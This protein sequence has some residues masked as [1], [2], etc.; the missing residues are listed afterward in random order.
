LPLLIGLFGFLALQAVILLLSAVKLS[1]EGISEWRSPQRITAAC[2]MR[3][4][5]T[6]TSQRDE[7]PPQQQTVQRHHQMTVSR[8]QRT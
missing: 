2:G 4:L 6:A 1:R 8:H 7:Y 5:A 3:Q